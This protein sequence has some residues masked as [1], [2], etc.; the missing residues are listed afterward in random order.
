LFGLAQRTPHATICSGSSTPRSGERA[1]AGR[2]QR[3]RRQAPS[4]QHD[5][6]SGPG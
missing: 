2:Q 6:P 1:T 3:A 4:H 5:D